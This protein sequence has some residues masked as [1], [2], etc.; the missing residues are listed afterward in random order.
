[1][2]EHSIERNRIASLGKRTMDNS[3]KVFYDEVMNSALNN[4]PVTSQYDKL[5]TRNSQKR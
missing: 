5:M 3:L 2:Y 1:M 4:V